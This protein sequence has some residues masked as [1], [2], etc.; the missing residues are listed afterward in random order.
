VHYRFASSK[1]LH[2]IEGILDGSNNGCRISDIGLIPNGFQVIYKVLSHHEHQSLSV[3]ATSIGKV[4][5]LTLTNAAG[6]QATAVASSV[7]RR[8]APPIPKALAPGR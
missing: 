2:P 6:F 7:A 5:R 8:Y 3:P 4:N 1:I